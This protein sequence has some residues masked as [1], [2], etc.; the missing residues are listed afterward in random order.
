[1]SSYRVD[2]SMLSLNIFDIVGQDG[3]ETGFVVHAG[4]VESAGSHHSAKIPVFDMAPPLHGQG[5]L[6]HIRANVVGGV[7]LTNDEVQK[8][9]TFVDRHIN[10]HLVF[11]QFSGRQL[12]NAAEQLYC[13]F[14]HALP[15]CEDDGRYARMRFSCVGFVFEAYKSARIKLLD[16]NDLPMVDFAV[17]RSA[18]PRSVHLMENRVINPEALGLQGSGPWPVLLCGYLFHALNRDADVIRHEPYAPSIAD[19]YFM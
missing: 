12:F 3:D 10:E 17:I 18:Y 1:M 9:K 15:F 19:R 14:P 16:S 2:E 11:Q 4:L 5:N 13:V 6:G 7:S 8:I